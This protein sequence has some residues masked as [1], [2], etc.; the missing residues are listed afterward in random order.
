MGWPVHHV[1]RFTPTNS[2]GSEGGGSCTF[3]GGGRLRSPEQEQWLQRH[4]VWP[5]AP[6]AER[7]DVRLGQQRAERPYH[8]GRQL[9]DLS[10]SHVVR[11]L[12]CS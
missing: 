3:C 5:A 6:A 4:C 2:N 9:P 7:G 11:P 12:T 1:S 10:P 8:L